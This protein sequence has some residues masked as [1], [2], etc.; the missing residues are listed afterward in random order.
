[1]KIKLIISIMLITAFVSCNL[2]NNSFEGTWCITKVNYNLNDQNIDSLKLEQLLALSLATNDQQP[3]NIVISNDTIK[4][5]SNREITEK[6]YYRVEKTTDN[7]TS[8]LLENKYT[9]TITKSE[10]TYI[11]K[12]EYLS[13][14]FEKC[15]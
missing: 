12:S 1:M 8:V 2:I 4:L 9:A 13:F 15:N 3:T 6:I 10:D 5:L 14:H 11:L 7:I